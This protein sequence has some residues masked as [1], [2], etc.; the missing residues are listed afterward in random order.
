M[1]APERS[2]VYII[3]KAPRAGVSKTRLCPPLEPAQAAGLAR[4]LL[5]DTLAA[6]HG[7]GIEG[8][9]MCRDASE[10]AELAALTGRHL[11]VH[12]QAGSGLGDALESA[13]RTGLADGFAAVGVLAADSPTVPPAVLHPAFT[14]LEDERDVALGRSEDGGYYLLA[15]RALHPVLFRDMVWSTAMVAQETL[16]RCRATGLRCRLLPTWYDVDDAA[17]LAR[18]RT[19]LAQAPRHVAPH[20]RAML[21]QLARSGPALAGGSAPHRRW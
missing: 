16:D 9:I 21:A 10:R 11:A 19:D 7:A 14:R 17:G 6:V 2:V 18:L 8:R 12:V 3:A 5:L 1:T 15:A 4:A 20:T 13:F